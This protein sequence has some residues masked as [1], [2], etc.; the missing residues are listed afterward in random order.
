MNLISSAPSSRVWGHADV[1]PATRSAGVSSQAAR[2][3]SRLLQPSKD[4][5][6]PLDHGSD[7]RWPSRVLED[8]CEFGDM[9]FESTNR[10][11]LI[12]AGAR[13]RIRPDP[14]VD[15]REMA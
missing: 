12:L 10:L 6:Q 9:V 14:E 2:T 1:T 13:P 7:I 15:G 8:D 11:E 3:G 4:T 5:L